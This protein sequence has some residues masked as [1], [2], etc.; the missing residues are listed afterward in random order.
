VHI[1]SSMILAEPM[2]FLNRITVHKVTYTFAPNFFLASL[3]QRLLE[4]PSRGKE[5][6]M[7]Q[8]T[9]AR[10]QIPKQA[11][12]DLSS[13]RAFISGGESNVVQTC[14]TLTDLL[15]HFGAPRSFIRPGFGMTETCAGSIYNA[16]DCPAYDLAR[17][18][19]FACL[20]DCIPGIHFRFCR[21]DGS[22]AA[23]DEVGELQV[24]GELVF[25]GYYRDACNSAKSFT[26]DGW[27][28]TGDRGYKDPNGRL[29]LIG[30]DKDTVIING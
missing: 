8:G 2:V 9:D 12:V 4:A 24:T 28:K 22:V 7:L 20:G 23:D 19:E 5:N 17:N 18:A 6:E 10:V 14:S 3:V 30:R 21:Q 13:L 27:F 29:H 15:Q 26:Q 11:A 16:I 1:P 25:K